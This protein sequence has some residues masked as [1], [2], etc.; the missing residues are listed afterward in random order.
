MGDKVEKEWVNYQGCRIIKYE[1]LCQYK[2]T[3]CGKRLH[4]FCDAN[5][6]DCTFNRE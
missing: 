6:H 3:I 1:G 4:F 5:A 2:C